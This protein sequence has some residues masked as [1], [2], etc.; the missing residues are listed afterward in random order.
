MQWKARQHVSH[1]CCSRPARALHTLLPVEA[2]SAHL[3]PHCGAAAR[4]DHLHP[5]HAAVALAEREAAV[6]CG[7]QQRWDCGASWVSFRACTDAT[8]PLSSSMAAPLQSNPHSQATPHS[9]ATGARQ[10]RFSPLTRVLQRG[11]HCGHKGAGSRVIREADRCCR[12][13]DRLVCSHQ[14][15]QLPV[16]AAAGS[17]CCCCRPGS[18]SRLA[19]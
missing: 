6:T 14:V 3:E 12:G 4:V 18:G 16:A 11:P 13:P 15:C 5:H 2:C 19:C 10:Q 7:M 17:C 9:A 8:W 1:R